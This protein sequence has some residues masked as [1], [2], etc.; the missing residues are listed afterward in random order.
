MRSGVPSISALAEVVYHSPIA[1]QSNGGDNEQHPDCGE[2]P[3]NSQVRGHL[4][5]ELVFLT[6]CPCALL[7]AKILFL[8]P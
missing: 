2:G 5:S 7:V 8:C 6:A 3:A 4:G 1:N